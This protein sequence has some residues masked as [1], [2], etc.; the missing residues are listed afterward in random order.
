MSNYHTSARRPNLLRHSR[1]VVTYEDNQSGKIKT[2]AVWAA[3]A[4]IA[5]ARTVN[6]IDFNKLHTG[7]SGYTL[8]PRVSKAEANY[9]IN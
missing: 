7:E 4:S 9:I 5:I 8:L 3:L 2:F 6:F 1:F